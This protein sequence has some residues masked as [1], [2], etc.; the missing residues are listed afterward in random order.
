MS[1]LSIYAVGLLIYNFHNANV[2][3]S[4]ELVYDNLDKQNLVQQFKLSCD[5][6][7]ESQLSAADAIMER[8][9]KIGFDQ[10]HHRRKSMNPNLYKAGNELMEFVQKLGKTTLTTNECY[11][12]AN[13]VY[14]YLEEGRISIDEKIPE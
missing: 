10:N 14:F 5:L 12:Y 7:R 3:P 6:D 13:R 8:I 4:Q 1:S 11:E 2:V 9:F